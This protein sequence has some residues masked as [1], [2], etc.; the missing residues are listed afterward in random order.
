[1]KT[2]TSKLLLLI[3]IAASLLNQGCATMFSGSKAKIK[4]YQGEP[5]HARIYYRGY[6]EGNAPMT[7][8]VPK[9]EINKNSNKNKIEIKSQGYET[10]TVLL[11]RR[12][13]G[14]Y[15][16][17]DVVTGFPFFPVGIL[18]LFIDGVTYSW[19]GVYQNNIRYN[20][21]ELPYNLDKQKVIPDQTEATTEK[22]AKAV[23]Q[24]QK[25]ERQKTETGFESKAISAE[26]KEVIEK[27]KAETI[28]KWA[29]DKKISLFKADNLPDL[30]IGS[31][32]IVLKNKK[33]INDTRLHEIHSNLI[34][35]EKQGSLHDLLIDEIDRIVLK[36]EKGYFV[37]DQ[38]NK[39]E[40]RKPQSR[41]DINIEESSFAYILN[42]YVGKEIDKNERD[43][44]WLFPDVKGFITAQLIA[45]SQ[46]YYSFNI[47]YKENNKI[48]GQAIQINYYDAK[49][50]IDHFY[51]FDKILNRE[52]KVNR[53]L[54]KLG[55][56]DS[57]P[58]R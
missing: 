41:P 39:P 47:N 55:I 14:G 57:Y 51:E 34:A 35:Y 42:M 30:P 28:L 49:Y 56:A 45:S 26:Q 6:Y 17:L 27:K 18:A 24:K 43:Y 53:H 10:K 54:V 12:F 22:T 29:G 33:L 46:Y 2:N 31:C 40:Y 38:N 37:F 36:E 58:G 48:K 5:K 21:K 25:T 11:K 19:F 44:Y 52:K 15:L 9:K 23:Q 4:V 16:F 8:K 50:L 32:M 7:L 13:K 1:M 3:I 20:L